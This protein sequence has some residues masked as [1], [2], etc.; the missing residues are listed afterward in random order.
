MLVKARRAQV[1]SGHCTQLYTKKKRKRR[2]VP[3]AGAQNTIHYNW[4]LI[5][6]FFYMH[7]KLRNVLSRLDGADALVIQSNCAPRSCARSLH[8]NCLGRDSNSYSPRYRPSA[9]TNRPPC[10]ERQPSS[11]WSVTDFSV[12]ASAYE[13]TTA[14]RKSRTEASLLPRGFVCAYVYVLYTH[15]YRAVGPMC[16]IPA[17]ACV[18]LCVSV[19]PLT[20]LCTHVTLCAYVY[21]CVYVLCMYACV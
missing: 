12:L 14:E 1:L 6:P 21:E 16:I 5:S 4:S 2:A 8:S 13:D 3:E 15:V 11:V 19:W 9:L 10:H 20:C 18:S 17:C 7:A